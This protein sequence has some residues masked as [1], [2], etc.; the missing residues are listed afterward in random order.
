MI[1]KRVFGYSGKNEIVH[2]YDI[3][4]KNNAKISVT[5]ASCAIVSAIMPDRCG[6]FADVLL[7]YDEPDNYLCNWMCPGAVIGRYAGRIGASRFELNGT[8]Y[9]LKKSWPGAPYTLH[10][11]K[12]GFQ[13]RIWSEYDTD[14]ENNSVTFCMDSKDGDQGYPG[15]MFVKVTYTLTDNNEIRIKYEAETDADTILNMTNHAYFNLGG[16]DSGTALSDMVK[17]YADKVL[18]V[19]KNMLPTGEIKSV[20]N[21]PLDFTEWKMVSEDFDKEQTGFSFFSGYDNCYVLGESGRMKKAAAVKNEKSGRMME[22]YTDRPAM[23]FYTANAVEKRLKGKNGAAYAEGNALCFETQLL[24]D[25]INH[26]NFRKN[27]ILRANEKFMSET[28][29]RFSVF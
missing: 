26:D 25:E 3:T 17:I 16:H 21:S 9:K 29:Y 4:N 24:T 7:G 23:Q 27:S 5:Q 10:S 22:V 19:D 2:I 20:K 14:A 1:E 13:Y 11:G 12:N 15:N 28:I 6:K 8:K 18:V